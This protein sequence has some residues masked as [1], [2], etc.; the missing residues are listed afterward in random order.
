MSFLLFLIRWLLILISREQQE[1]ED[2]EL[3][4]LH[5]AAVRGEMR[6]KKR[7]HGVGMEDSDDDSDE[8]DRARK[9]RRDMYKKRKIDRDNIK[10]LGLYSSFPFTYSLYTERFI[11]RAPRD[12]VIFPGV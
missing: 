11:R 7:N 2:Q 4:K 5:Q 1:L 3:E 12:K 6:Q 8:D 9:I 10:E